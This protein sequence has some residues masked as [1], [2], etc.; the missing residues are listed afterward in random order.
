MGKKMRGGEH[1]RRCRRIIVLVCK[2]GLC[3]CVCV[4]VCL[5]VCVCVVHLR[6]LGH[7]LHLLPPPMLGRVRL[8]VFGRVRSGNAEDIG[9]DT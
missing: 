7:A 5:C 8:P 3:V 4:C 9:I 6:L 1:G 2:L